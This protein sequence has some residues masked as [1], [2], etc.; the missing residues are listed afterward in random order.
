M[1]E[2]DVLLLREENKVV[3]SLTQSWK[4]TGSNLSLACL[5]YH[6]TFRHCQYVLANT[7]WK[8]KLKK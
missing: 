6:Y 4:T 2:D 3:I 8:V 7:L 1:L 5:V